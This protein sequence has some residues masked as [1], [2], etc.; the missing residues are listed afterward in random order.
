VVTRKANGQ[1]RKGQLS[2]LDH[3]APFFHKAIEIRRFT[4]GS[5]RTPQMDSWL[6]PLKKQKPE[7]KLE[8][9]G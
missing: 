2:D 8:L 3:L 6:G 7:S 9:L 5:N 4:V 1:N